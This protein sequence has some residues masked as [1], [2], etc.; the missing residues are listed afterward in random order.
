MPSPSRPRYLACNTA[1]CLWLAVYLPVH[2]I[3]FVTLKDSDPHAALC[4]GLAAIV[5]SL[6][7]NCLVTMWVIIPYP[8]STPSWPPAPGTDDGKGEGQ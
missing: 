1:L 5:A 6:M 2:M 8:P 3:V 4:A 7:A